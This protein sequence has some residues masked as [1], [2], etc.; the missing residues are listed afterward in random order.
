MTH[1]VGAIELGLEIEWR[2]GFVG[3]GQPAETTPGAVYLDVGGTVKAGVLDHHAGTSS[4]HC[5]AELVLKRRDAIYDHLL[6]PWLPPVRNPGDTSRIRWTPVLVTHIDPDWDSVV[7]SFLAIRLVEDGDFPDYAAGLVQ[8]A[9][10]VDQGRYHIDIRQPE[11]LLA[12]HVGYLAIQNQLGSDGSPLDSEAQLRAG[13]ELVQT[14]VNSM[15]N[16]RNSAGRGP[17]LEAVDFFPGSPGVTNWVDDARFASAAEL[18]R[19]DQER[20]DRDLA[21]AQILKDV[22][23]P[24][25]D[26]G[27]AITVP[28]FLAP[29]PMES[30][31]HKYW[32]RASGYPFFICP[33]ATAVGR[34]QVCKEVPNKSAVFPRV[35]LSVD[36]TFKVKDRGLSLLGLGYTLEKE[37]TRIRATARGGEDDRPGPPRFPDG[38]CTN[39][40]PWYDGRA[41]GSYTI[42]DA[43]RC[44]TVIPY[45]RVVEIATRTRY[46]ELPLKHA[47]VSLIWAGLNQD[48]AAGGAKSAI[49]HFEGASTTLDDY[50]KQCLDT[51]IPFR[52]ENLKLSEGVALSVIWRTFPPSTCPPMHI[53]ILNAREGTTLETLVAAR[54]RVISEFRAGIPDF[55]LAKISL[56]THFRAATR[57]DRLLRQLADEELQTIPNLSTDGRIV[58]FNSRR[59]IFRENAA[60]LEGEIDSEREILLYLAFLTESLVAFSGRINRTL[61]G[62]HGAKRLSTRTVCRDFL[63]F[64]TKYYQID[65]CRNSRGRILVEQLSQS[66]RLADNYLE[67]RSELERLEQLENQTVERSLQAVLYFI[68]VSGV[69]QTILA[70]CSTDKKFLQSGLFWVGMIG[71]LFGAVLIFG[72]ITWW[73]RGRRE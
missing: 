25:A 11:S 66:L 73:R 34:T 64:Q 49:P 32:V 50:F 57:A 39:D 36:P 18:I 37:E 47:S 69:Y 28:C 26:G 16:A 2:F 33:F 10:E 38:Y 3:A 42:V 72:T 59:L 31:L 30:V 6:G 71:V 70:F 22:P 56:G 21:R 52:S 17:I 12:P 23:V 20:F 35:V 58:L 15:S 67:V 14:L 13:L 44:G 43:P 5:A 48:V 19:V 51:P 40:D 41:F 55:G 60:R 68:A 29:V 24:G 62:G 54:E 53:L 7:A 9:S 27:E 63:G 46:W 1:Y 61:P 45:G 4:C 65:V 8:Y